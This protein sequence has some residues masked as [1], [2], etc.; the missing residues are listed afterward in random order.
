MK[1]AVLWICAILVVETSVTVAKGS[2]LVAKGLGAAV[3]LAARRCAICEFVVEGLDKRIR[4]RFG[5]VEFALLTSMLVQ[6]PLSISVVCSLLVRFCSW[7][8]DDFRNERWIHIDG[9]LQKQKKPDKGRVP[10][11]LS[12]LGFLEHLEETCSR[13]S[14][15]SALL[16]EKKEALKLADVGI[17]DE[18][19]PRFQDSYVLTVLSCWCRVR[20]MPTAKIKAWRFVCAHASGCFT[21][22]QNLACGILQHV[23]GL[24]KSTR[25]P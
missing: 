25:K 20:G 21:H 13:K 24:W 4:V 9:R 1:T 15:L 19:D 6:L 12:E 11:G 17:T 8:Q 10:Y 16:M 18:E 7:Y 3:E 5:D 14:V 22:L 23:V 2:N